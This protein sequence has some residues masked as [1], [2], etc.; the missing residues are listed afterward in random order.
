M[1]KVGSVLDEF[2]AV[3]GFHRKHAMRLLLAASASLNR[4]STS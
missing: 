4:K 2:V 3:T 1:K